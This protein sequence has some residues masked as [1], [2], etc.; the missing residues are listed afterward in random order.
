MLCI[1]TLELHCSGLFSRFGTV[2]IKYDY[3]HNAVPKSISLVWSGLG[4]EDTRFEA[5]NHAVVL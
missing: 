5:T 3:S 2:Y 1:R 4:G